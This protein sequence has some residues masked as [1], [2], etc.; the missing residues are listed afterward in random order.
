LFL[1]I[2]REPL[3]LHD[4]KN[5][6]SSETNYIIFLRYSFLYI[7]VVYIHVFTNSDISF[8]IYTVCNLVTKYNNY[9]N[10]LLQNYKNNN[11]HYNITLKSTLFTFI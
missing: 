11:R 1:I 4:H 10:I 9:N 3:Y 6:K 2:L 5:N 8:I 7:I